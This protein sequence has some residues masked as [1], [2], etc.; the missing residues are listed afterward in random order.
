MLLLLNSQSPLAL[1][2]LSSL[3]TYVPTAHLWAAYC[4]RGF[5][6][7]TFT[8]LQPHLS[9]PLSPATLHDCPHSDFSLRRRVASKIL[10]TRTQSP[11]VPSASTRPSPSPSCAP[12]R[13]SS[14]RA[15][16]PQATSHWKTPRPSCAQAGSAAP[17]DSAPGP[18][19]LGSAQAVRARDPGTLLR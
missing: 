7:H 11:G 12:L 16:S 15:P 10:H 8:A 17:P 9:S 19:S 4:T 6:P 18:D 14:R 13:A 3:P 1:S 5:S 2:S